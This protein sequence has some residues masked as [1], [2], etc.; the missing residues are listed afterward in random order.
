MSLHDLNLTRASH[1]V[2]VSE[3]M[4]EE[5]LDNLREHQN[6]AA[7]KIAR[8]NVEVNGD[9]AGAFV[10]AIVGQTQ[11][12]M[13]HPRKPVARHLIDAP[14]L[15]DASDYPGGETIAPG[16]GVVTFILGVALLTLLAFGL[17]WAATASAK[18][19]TRQ[20]AEWREWR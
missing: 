7:I 15:L 19:A 6:R 12:E 3:R 20:A 11:I 14:A 8:W 17:W 2:I 9:Q 5:A 16:P 4:L 13:R 1:S 10:D 18:A